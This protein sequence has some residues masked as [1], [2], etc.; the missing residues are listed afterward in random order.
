MSNEQRGRCLCGNVTYVVSGEARDLSYCHCRSCR[1]ATGAL[2]V[3]WG[4]VDASGFRL[5]SGKLKIVRSSAEVERGFCG[6][7]GSSLTYQHAQRNREIDFTL[8]TVDDASAMAPVS[9]IWVRDKLPWEHIA[10]GL[11]AYETASPP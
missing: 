9:H 8:A 1:R 4:T 5:T 3:A 2:F 10:D 7:C 11:P 6:D